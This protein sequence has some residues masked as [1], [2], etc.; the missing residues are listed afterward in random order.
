VIIGVDARELQGRPTGTGR[1]LRSLL[2]RWTEDGTEDRFV[3]YFNGAAP[4]DSLLRRP[5]ILRQ[6]LTTEPVHSLAWQEWHLPAAVRRD[7]IEVFFSPAYTCPL[8]LRIPRVTAVHDLSFFSLPEDFS[9]REAVRRRVLTGLSIGA[10]RRVLACSSF[11]HRE[12][13]SRFPAAASRVREIPLGPDEDLPAGP[14]R[15]E[16]RARLHALGPL[17]LTVGTLLN[18]RRLPTLLH[19]TSLLARR[20]PNLVLDVVGDNRTHPHVDFGA[21]VRRLGLEQR[22][23][24]SGFVTEAGL[25]DRYAAADV[26]VF[27]SE[28]EGFGLPALEAAA[29]GVPLV[30]SRRP[31]LC[32]VFAGAARFVEPEDPAAVAT[33]VGELLDQE[34]VRA[35]LVARGLALAARHSWART[36]SLTRQALAEAAD[37]P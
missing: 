36:A 19:A 33:A 23:R 21:Q 28:Y 6:S 34:T 7:R 14:P 9:W 31:S 18:R 4:D 27:L 24:L 3:A 30:L 22:V 32:E 20:F 8:R 29:R 12:I 5:E 16:A 13:A 25:A 37:E 35:N 1:Y 2:R 10:S 11:T 26:A 17:L 15:A